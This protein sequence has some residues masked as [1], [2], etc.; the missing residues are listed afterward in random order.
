MKKDTY[1]MSVKDA[2]PEKNGDEERKYSFRTI[3]MLGK[4]VCDM[5]KEA[6]NFV[7]ATGF[8][9]VDSAFG[10]D[11]REIEPK[12]SREAL[13]EQQARLEAQGMKYIPSKRERADF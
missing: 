5:A 4:G 1:T 6:C 2:R 11:L 3:A 13:Q 9:P 8:I 10:S 12:V 7:K